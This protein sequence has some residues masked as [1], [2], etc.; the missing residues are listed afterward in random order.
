MSYSLR[1]GSNEFHG[2]PYEYRKG[3]VV[4][5]GLPRIIPERLL[6]RFIDLF[7]CVS[8]V[9]EAHFGQIFAPSKR[10]PPHL[11]VVVKLERGYDD[12][13]AEL[14]SSMGLIVQEVLPK[15]QW[16]EIMFN[17][18]PFDGLK[19]FYHKGP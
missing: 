1:S 3:D 16:L 2:E 17:E 5:A 9:E 13:F 11:I 19:L 8:F 6:S 4:Y 18:T 10:E 14:N 15:G 12:K 7:R